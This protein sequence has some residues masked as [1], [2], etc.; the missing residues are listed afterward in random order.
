MSYAIQ[1]SKR[2]ESYMDRLDR[3]TRR[4]MWDRIDEVAA[5]RY[6]RKSKPLSGIP[7]ARPARVG[8]YRIVFEVDDRAH[9][10][11]V[12]IVGPRGQVSRDV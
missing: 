5:E 4:R 9:A 10:V 7:G 6:G 12:T 8:D 3:T 1:L 11:L 2:A